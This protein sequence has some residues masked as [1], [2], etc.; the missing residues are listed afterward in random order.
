MR[1]PSSLSS[2]RGPR[3]KATLWGLEM[4]TL[5]Q[6]SP[7]HSISQGV[8]VATKPTL[9]REQTG[10]VSTLD[11]GVRL[12]PHVQLVAVGEP[13]QGLWTL[14]LPLPSEDLLELAAWSCGHPAHGQPLL[15]SKG[16]ASHKAPATA[17]MPVRT[18]P[19]LIQ[20]C[21]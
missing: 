19:V 7:A 14:M 10:A 12:F 6:A 5:P 9:A 1:F 4:A 21:G 20:R 8:V 3:L 17:D 11:A 15:S 13:G 18:L 2:R 16:R